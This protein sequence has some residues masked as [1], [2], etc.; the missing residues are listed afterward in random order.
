MRVERKWSHFKCA[1]NGQKKEAGGEGWKITRRSCLLRK[2][3]PHTHIGSNYSTN[4]H[5][6]NTNY[7][8]LLLRCATMCKQGWARPLCLGHSMRLVD[9]TS[10]RI[11]FVHNRRISRQLLKPMATTIAGNFIK[12]KSN[13]LHPIGSLRITEDNGLRLGYS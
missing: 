2:S 8:G 7:T 9:L 13:I 5:W 4:L 10:W 1:V 3:S 11:P 6:Y 12:T